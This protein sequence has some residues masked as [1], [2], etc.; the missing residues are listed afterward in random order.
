[1]PGND[2]DPGETL[3]AFSAYLTAKKWDADALIVCEAIAESFV[4]YLAATDLA[5]SQVTPAIVSEYM[6][7]RGRCSGKP[8]I[9]SHYSLLE[10]FFQLLVREGMIEENPITEEIISRLE[11]EERK[12]DEDNVSYLLRKP[13]FYKK[14]PGQFKLYLGTVE[15]IVEMAR[16]KKE[17]EPD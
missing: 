14:G 16:R 13:G 2:R 1:M 5:V 15:E 10:V 9:S 7:W 8:P 12:P 3:A 6:K 11:N 17:E 4:D